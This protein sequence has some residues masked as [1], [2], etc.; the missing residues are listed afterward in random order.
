V[1]VIDLRRRLGLPDRAS[2][3]SA[4]N[5]VVRTDDGTV[6]LLVDEIGDVLEMSQTAFEPPPENIRGIAR[7]LTMGV[8]KLKDKLLIALN[9]DRV[10]H[11]GESV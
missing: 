3:A 8:Y 7:E 6:S 10:V 1:T 9:M 11:F 5:V 2:D 4:I